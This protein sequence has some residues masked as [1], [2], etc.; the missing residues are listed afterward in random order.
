MNK[1][2]YFFVL[3]AMLA[4]GIL[5]MGAL[6]LVSAYTRTPEKGQTTNLAEDVLDFFA[7]TKIEDFNNP[8]FGPAGTL[9][10]DGTIKD[11]QKTLLQQLGEFYYKYN[12]DTSDETYLTY[13]RLL[14]TEVTEDIVPAQYEY[15]FL[16]DDAK[17]YPETSTDQS[18]QNSEVLFPARKICFETIDLTL[19]LF[20]PYEAEVLIWR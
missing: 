16:I 3:D 8:I 5:V 15:E 13:A 2:A 12:L 18:K 20:G 17:I 19:D 9:V 7:D 1:K 4:L 6:L 11:A 14:I 10:Q